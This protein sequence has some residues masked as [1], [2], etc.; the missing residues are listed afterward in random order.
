MTGNPVKQ[1]IQD[2]E[3]TADLQGLSETEVAD[4]RRR[5]LGHSLALKSSRSYA[6]ILRTNIFVPVNIIMF[7]LGQAL[8]VLGQVSDALISVGVAFFNVLVGT[9]QEIR[10]KRVLDHITLLTRPKA[11]VMRDGQEHLVDPSELVVGDIL[12]VRPGD[13]VLVDGQV[14]SDAR[15]EVDESLLSGES[16]L[17]LKQRGDW[18]YSGSFCVSGSAYYL[19]RKVGNE[20]VAN[21]LAAGARAFRP[22]GLLLATSVAYALGAVRMGG[23]GVLV[24]QANA[25]EALSNVDVLCLDKTGTLT[26][27]AL[28]LEGVHPLNIEEAQL[29]HLLGEYVA[30]AAA[31]NLTS[32]AIGAACPGERRHA[33]EEVAFS[34]ARKWSTLSIDDA[35]LQGIYVLGA[36]DI[37]QPFLRQGWGGERDIGTP[38][39]AEIA[40]GRRVLLFA[41][42]PSSVSLYDGQ[43][44]PV[45]PPDLTPLGF[46]SLR[47]QLRPDAQQTLV[48]SSR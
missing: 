40:G 31:G 36:P 2:K 23:L 45:L 14:V 26:A 43:G 47:D 19:A 24:Q 15:L 34:S 13:Q 21:Q 16:E 20:S 37:L 17:V 3:T 38:M 29:R 11:T 35:A 9:V 4:R 8:I 7:A 18:L 33:R 12:V 25:I 22:K 30:S 39:Q 44:D 28:V 48:S 41:S 6:R 32:A 10:A 42:C 27:N 5:G 1:E 46:I